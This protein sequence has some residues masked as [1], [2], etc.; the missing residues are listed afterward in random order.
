MTN[1]ILHRCACHAGFWEKPFFSS[2]GLIAYF[3]CS[4]S[5]SQSRV[6]STTSFK[7]LPVFNVHPSA[8]NTG[9]TTK[10]VNHGV[11]IPCEYS[12]CQHSIC[13]PAL[14]A[15]NTDRQ[16]IPLWPFGGSK[17]RVD[18]EYFP[19]FKG[20]SSLIFGTEFCLERSSVF[21]MKDQQ[22]LQVS[23]FESTRYSTG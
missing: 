13:H 5:L 7:T 19:V 15:I 22:S 1:P 6:R 8:Q 23:L 9:S 21:C 14:S 2:L 18:R 17:N 16:T 3:S 11:A 4:V 12:I 10:P 20:T